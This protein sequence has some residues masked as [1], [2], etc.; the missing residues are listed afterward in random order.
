MKTLK[1]SAIALVLLCA[2]TSLVRAEEV[3][4][5]TTHDVTVEKNRT[6]W[7]KHEE[8]MYKPGSNV[9]DLSQLDV[10]HDGILTKNEIGAALFR[11][12]DTDGNQLIDN[13][14]FEKK[15]IATVVPM[16]ATETVSWYSGDN[17]VPDKTVVSTA[18]F[19]KA[20]QLARF[21]KNGDGLS[22]RDFAA[23]TF[24]D[25]DI[26]HDHFVDMKE[27]QGA[28]NAAINAQNVKEQQFSTNK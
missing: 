23:K 3:T 17:E 16:K 26:N 12:F 9:L 11:I 8:P 25:A 2:S 5:V 19:M 14:E 13:V 15:V 28:Y 27:W 1:H 18:D 10:N 7:V 20:T 24:E 4:T 6:E 21:D 22:P